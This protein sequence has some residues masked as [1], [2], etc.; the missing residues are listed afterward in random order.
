[1]SEIDISDPN[2]ATAHPGTVTRLRTFIG[3]DGDFSDLQAQ[4]D[5]RFEAVQTQM[6]SR[7]SGVNTLIDSANYQISIRAT[8]DALT[9]INDTLTTTTNTLNSRL[10]TI[11]GTVNGSLSGRVSALETSAWV[12]PFSYAET[13]YTSGVISTSAYALKGTLYQ[14][15]STTDLHMFRAY[16]AGSSGD[17]AKLVIARMTLSGSIY[18]VAE[19]IKESSSVSWYGSDGQSKFFMF[20]EPARLVSGSYYAFVIVLTSGTGTSVLKIPFPTG[21]SSDLS[22]FATYVLSIRES[23]NSFP[24]GTTLIQYNNTSYIPFGFGYSLVEVV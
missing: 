6:D 16:Y 2:A 13:A 11:E 12:Y 20:T 3:V 14:C 8:L 17:L 4:I 1:M 7:F 19:I 9:G 22:P 15:T 23:I 5:A 10:T 18:T 21:T 24:V